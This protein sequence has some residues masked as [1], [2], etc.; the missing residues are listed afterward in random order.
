MSG[1]ED[2]RVAAGRTIDYEEAKRLAADPSPEARARVA[3]RTDVQPEILYFL[4]NDDEPAVR[5]AAAANEATPVHAGLV[6][7]RDSD[8][9]VRCS[10]AER[11]GRLAPGL[12]EEARAR[13]GVIVNDVL[14]TLARDQLGRVRRIIAD[15]V[16]DS[17]AVP[18]SVVEI[19][20]NDDDVEI[21]AP[22]LEFSP[23]LD[24]DMLI[25]IIEGSPASGT[26]AAIS[27]RSGLRAP[28]AE[29]IVAADD[30]PAI[31]E[32]T[33]T[34]RWSAARSC[35]RRRSAGWPGSSPM[36]W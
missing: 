3:A 23:L 35:R 32:R 16:K 26:L 11:I 9:K 22:V 2:R 36:P 5:V 12:D 31:T 15:A 19:L 6:L 13:V 8:E 10:L 30:A 4:A 20:A 28:V 21:A 34:R 25:E 33:G 14:E 17:D 27:R 18:R 7:A 29:A 24:D 1:F